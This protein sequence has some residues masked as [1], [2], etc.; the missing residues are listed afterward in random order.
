[1]LVSIGTVPGL[2]AFAGQS[3]DRGVLQTDVA[4]GE[5]GEFLDAGGG[6]VEGGQQ[7]CVTSALAGGPV[8]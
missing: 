6:V 7:G 2:A 4:N 3:D 1:V 5:V 8:G